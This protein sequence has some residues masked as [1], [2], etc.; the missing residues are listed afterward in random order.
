MSNTDFDGVI[1]E[2]LK[3]ASTQAAVAPTGSPERT[4]KALALSER[5]GVAPDVIQ[6]NIEK[7]QQD[8]EFNERSVMVRGSPE[9]QAYVQGNPMA[10]QVS[11]DDYSALG[12]FIDEMKNF[13]DTDPMIKATR[14]AFDTQTP[15]GIQP[16]G[17]TEQFFKDIGLFQDDR[18]L[19]AGALVTEPV[20]RIVPAA[21]DLISRAF[22]AA[23]AGAGAG[24][25]AL[26]RDANETVGSDFFGS[27]KAANREM[28]NFVNF[29][30][31]KQGFDTPV[32]L[33]P[34]LPLSK[35][36]FEFLKAAEETK[37]GP[38][39]PPTPPWHMD[40]IKLQIE[41]Q[42][43][44]AEFDAAQLDATVQS[45]VETATRERS[46]AMF[47][48]LAE[49]NLGDRTIGV[50]P[51]ALQEFYKAE[52]I[53]P[54][55]GDPVMGFVPDIA[56][57]MRL[58]LATGT[59]VEVPFAA[60]LAHIDPK[61]HEALLP[62]IR[63]KGGMTIEEA[64]AAQEEMEA[65][66]GA[67]KS[68]LPPSAEE[69]QKILDV[70]TYTDGN[71][72]FINEFLRGS[73]YKQNTF[74]PEEMNRIIFN[75]DD[76]IQRD[77]L[78]KDTTLYRF[79]RGIEAGKLANLKVGETIT[80]PQFLS[81]TALEEIP[82]FGAEAHTRITIKA[83]AGTNA[84][85][86]AELSVYKHQNE[87][88]LPRGTTLRKTGENEFE[89][90]LSKKEQVDMGGGPGQPAIQ[91]E[92]AGHPLVSGEGPLL[93]ATVTDLPGIELPPPPEGT[94]RVYHSGGPYEGGTRWVSTSP[95]YVNY[96]AGLIPFYADLPVEAFRAVKGVYDDVNNFYRNVDIPA[97]LAK[98]LKPITTEHVVSGPIEAGVTKA[99]DQL[100]LSP[101]FK[102]AESA[103]MTEREFALY[104]QRLEEIRTRARELDIARAQKQA[105]RELTQEWKATYAEE[106]ARAEAEF[107][108]RRDVVA[109]RYIKTDPIAV[110]ALNGVKLPKGM[111]IRGGVEPDDIA[112]FLGYSTGAELVEDLGRLAAEQGRKSDEGFRAATVKATAQGAAERRFGDP[113]ERAQEVVDLIAEEDLSSVLYDELRVMQKQG[114]GT[115]LTL[116][117][118]ETWA[119]REFNK[120]SVAEASK[121]KK[122]TTAVQK[123]GRQAE[124]ALLANDIEKAFKFKNQ[125]LMA[126]LF[127][128]NAIAF[129]RNLSRGVRIPRVPKVVD[130][131]VA[132]VAEAILP[133]QRQVPGGP[134]QKSPRVLIK[135]F[136]GKPP[137][138]MDAGYFI[139][140]QKILAGLGYKVRAT[141][142]ELKDAP[143]LPEFVEAVKNSGMEP[144]IAWDL[145][146]PMFYKPMSELTVEEFDG[147]MA[148]LRSLDFLGREAKT[149]YLNGKK[150]E[151]ANV[152]D[153]IVN[154]VSALPF[155]KVGQNT[156]SYAARTAGTRLKYGIDSR[157]VKMEE[158][159]DDLDLHDPHG[160]FNESVFVPIVKGEYREIE[161][162]QKVNKMLEGARLE[163]SKRTVLNNEFYDPMTGTPGN[164][165]FYRF[166]KA[167]VAMMALNFGNKHN[168]RLLVDTL[169]PPAGDVGPALLEMDRLGAEAQ[170]LAFIN[171]NMT[172]Q[173][174]TFV[175][176]IWYMQAWLKPQV[177][178]V[179]LRTAG[180]AP[181]TVEPAPFQTPY[182]E[183]P[184]GYTPVIS[185]P[186]RANTHQFSEGH[187]FGQQYFKATTPNAYTKPRS[188]GSLEPLLVQG[189]YTILQ[190][191]IRAMIHD[192][193]LR[194]PVINAGKILGNRKVREAVVAHYGS[195]YVQ[196]FDPWLKYIANHY[197]E[198]DRLIGT[199]NSIL[200]YGRTS[201]STAVLG[202]NFKTILSPN[203][204]PAVKAM[205]ELGVRATDVNYSL[206]NWKDFSEFALTNS[207]ELQTREY[208]IN[209]EVSDTLRDI[210]G[211]SGDL[212]RFHVDA[213]YYGML[214]T[215]KI[216]RALATIFWT[217]EYKKALLSGDTHE[218]AVD[219]ADKQVRKYHGSSSPANLAAIFRGAEPTKA[220]T[221][222]GS[223]MNMVYNRQ[224]SIVGGQSAK[225]GIELYQKGEN[226]GEKRDWGKMLADFMTISVVTALFGG[227]IYDPQLINE[228]DWGDT[229]IKLIL[230]SL[231]GSIPLIRD[232]YAYG[233]QDL[234]PNSLGIVSIGKGLIDLGRNLEAALDSDPRSH[235]SEKWVK[236]A[237]MAPG[238]ALGLPVGQFANSSQYLWNV[239]VGKDKMNDFGDFVRGIMY[240]RSELK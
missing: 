114:G 180:V 136:T 9:L 62:M 63:S 107:D 48:Q 226:A 37:P 15:L 229:V 120:L 89:V 18:G 66:I 183:Q 212:K 234:P 10:A 174:W 104:S 197:N 202:F 95:T 206:M 65:A 99:T 103:G 12:L 131:G 38:V 181:D 36:T 140:G 56:D 217:A 102:D 216:D 224:R 47:Q 75:M 14:E 128:Q 173:D 129:A 186:D 88:I 214:A 86:A 8:L 182:G 40:P 92:S 137:A 132:A 90:V 117:E 220:L 78:P 85:D 22:I 29:W 24:V 125:Q 162:Q 193:A 152:V 6:L 96:R 155:R 82:E 213:A 42:T 143:K 168:R 144:A 227:V 154:R 228:D 59:D 105:Q 33:N 2:Y 49:Q 110:E 204:G 121:P 171:R 61:V 21:F 165:D 130:P 190:H 159:A 55:V 50:S 231:A 116:Q 178:E 57:R 150:A 126:V 164:R 5:S 71:N 218:G 153:E 51:Q 147:V 113:G 158:V 17:E 219:V 118:L 201:V 32:M 222:F 200:R 149:V 1:D 74:T 20:I 23:T 60:Y 169:L 93:D 52:G 161:I 211:M 175:N 172:E 69:A 119:E 123:N 77:T 81:T 188:P 41:L 115:P 124:L 108:A 106:V 13:A 210:V 84:L 199:L 26:V 28:Q 30:L 221:V 46:P 236:N 80:V 70:G 198:E 157:L 31:Q 209:R 195:E 235:P 151:L 225:T 145:Y 35:R 53:V 73:K 27:P 139:Q 134:R 142:Q 215:A 112:G 127:L 156:S 68:T 64:K 223:Y 184:G 122:W 83:P 207:K 192:I 194:E 237:I 141:P 16:G 146:D 187:I 167:D 138:G 176:R 11:S 97:E 205:I 4:A 100:Y 111:A 203:V 72:V 43:T 177:D 233:F 109:A 240:G 34:E 44:K 45:A 101:L 135:T 79:T 170:V 196:T 91:A 232:L 208:N 87:F 185:D 76:L 160:P 58:A 7:F 19:D 98:L 67:R 191:K 148:S 25:E 39:T 230:S 239:S 179:Y 3:S 54:G 238:Q 133:R 166:T 189:Q 163:G 94:V